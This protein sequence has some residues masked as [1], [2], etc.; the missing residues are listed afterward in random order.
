[1]I[2]LD[3]PI[4]PSS[5]NLFMNLPK[6]R[7][8]ARTSEYFSWQ[9]EAGLHIQS[10][11]QKPLEGPVCVFLR[12]PENG[13]RDLDGYWKPILDILVKHR[14]IPDDRNKIVR[15][16]HAVWDKVESCRVTVTKAMEVADGPHPNN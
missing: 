14:L 5:N 1:M 16:L 11:R 9:I 8:R 2:V 4:P 13:R 10:A 6:G 3:L 12:V 7:G 15:E